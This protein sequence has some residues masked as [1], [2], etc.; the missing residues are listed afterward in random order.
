[1]PT[2]LRSVIFVYIF[3]RGSREIHDILAPNLKAWGSMSLISGIQ[4]AAL[5]PYPQLDW[6]LGLAVLGQPTLLAWY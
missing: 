3:H 1:M 4:V 5:K 6:E 2:A